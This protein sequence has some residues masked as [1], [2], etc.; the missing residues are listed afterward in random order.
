[1]SKQNPPRTIKA[2]KPKPLSNLK[3]L[4]KDS[5]E[6]QAPKMSLLVPPDPLA[7]TPMKY[8]KKSTLYSLSGIWHRWCKKEL[9]LNLYNNTLLIRKK[10]EEN[11]LYLSRYLVKNTGR[12]KKK[13]CF[14]LIAST[15]G[16]KQHK[17]KKIII[18]CDEKDAME[19]WIAL[20]TEYMTVIFFKNYDL[21][22]FL[23]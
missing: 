19:E 11:L 16:E 1:M 15:K 8:V 12:F 13:W 14:T 3:Y 22:K 10:G 20:L 21:H 6:L 18:G 9:V 5:D 4:K 23:K 2:I 17:N 7:L